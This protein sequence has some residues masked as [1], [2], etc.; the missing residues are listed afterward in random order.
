MKRI[1]F[2]LSMTSVISCSG[3]SESTTGSSNINQESPIENLNVQTANFSEIDS[4][5]V[6][7]FPLRMGESKRESESSSYKEIPQSEFWNIMFYNSAT[8]NYYLLTKDKILIEN[9][10]DDYYNDTE[11]ISTN[12]T[13]YIFYTARS[14]DYNKDKLLNHQDPLY[15]Y[16]SNK[17][18]E[19]FRQ[20][21]PNNFN[22]ENWKYIKSTNKVVFSASKD[23]NK[24]N[25]FD[26]KDE[27]IAFEVNVDSNELAKEIFSNETKNELKKLYDRDWK[28]V[29]K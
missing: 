22:L 1:I 14:L 12:K 18:G 17:K 25:L 27:V 5:G 19:N 10:N 23:S 28:K 16:V 20:L 7:I 9:F 24:N 21:S 26:D 15:L 8:N 13:N 3:N 4:S 2:I 29:K 6:L 11:T